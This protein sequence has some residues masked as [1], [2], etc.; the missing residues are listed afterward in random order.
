[1]Q[2]SVSAFATDVFTAAPDRGCHASAFI[3]VSDNLLINENDDDDDDD[4][5]DVVTR[6]QSRHWVS[7][8]WVMGQMGRQM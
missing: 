4:D 8:S 2:C 6:N 7:G 5:V 3:A 1:M